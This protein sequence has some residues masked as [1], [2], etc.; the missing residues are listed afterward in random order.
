[1]LF[2]SSGDLLDSGI[3]PVSLV[4]TGRFFSNEPPGKVEVIHTLKEALKILQ[5]SGEERGS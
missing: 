3:E 1:M 2:P 5:G 4:S